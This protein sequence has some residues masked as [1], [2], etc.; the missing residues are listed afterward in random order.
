M[1]VAPW[2]SV[3]DFWFDDGLEQGWPSRNLSALWFRADAALDQG[4]EAQFGHLVEAALFSELVEWEA[5]PLSR[6]ALLVLLD[7]FTRN[8]YRGSAKAFAGDHRA[9]TLVLE[10]LARGM[11]RELP[12]VG[13]VFFL[14]PL[15][16]AEDEDLQQRSVA[17]FTT[18]HAAAPVEMADRIAANLAFAREHRDIVLRFGR[19]PHRNQVLGRDSSDEER[20]FLE[21]G[22]RY[23]Q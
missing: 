8:I 16:H 2:Q 22:P 10:G 4:I 9:V 14:M 1:M 23:G 21:H 5:T 18:L 11:D 13:R 6:L 19:F 7:Q 20:A 17:E 15:M 3:L 12:W